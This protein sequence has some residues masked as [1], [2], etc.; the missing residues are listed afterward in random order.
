[1][2]CVLSKCSFTLAYSELSKHQQ[3]EGDNGVI[4]EIIARNFNICINY[5]LSGTRNFASVEHIIII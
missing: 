2:Y 3:E 5:T 4:R 1:M